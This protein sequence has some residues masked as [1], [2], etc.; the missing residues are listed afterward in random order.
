VIFRH[1]FPKVFFGFEFWTFLKMSIF[2]KSPTFYPKF[3]KEYI[4]FI[5]ELKELKTQN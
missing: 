2:E 3:C 1:I 4:I 5:K